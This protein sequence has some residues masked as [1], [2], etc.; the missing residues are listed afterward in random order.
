VIQQHTDTQY[1]VALEIGGHAIVPLSM[2]LA[3]R[4]AVLI[5][6]GNLPRHPLAL[7]VAASV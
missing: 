1:S 7:T 2:T 3:P 4:A 6:T 5:S